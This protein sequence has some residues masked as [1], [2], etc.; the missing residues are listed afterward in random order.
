MRL[1]SVSS[2]ASE[3]KRALPA[4]ALAPARSRLLW[5]PV[6]LTVIVLGALAIARDWVPMPFPWLV[7]LGIG[8]SFGGLSFLAHEVLHGAVVRSMWQ[9]RLVGW[10]GFL[11]FF[12]SPRLWI[13]WHNRVHHGHANQPG[14]DPDAFPTLEEYRRR[15]T[16]RLVTDWLE[17]GR[18]RVAGVL[19]LL[20]GFSVHSLHMLASAKKSGLLSA[21]AR[22]WALLESAGAAAFWVLLALSIGWGPFMLVYA[23]PLLIANA[24]VMAHIFTNHGLSPLTPVNDPL[25]NS[26]SVTAPRWFEWITLRFGFHVEHHLFPWM[27][28]RHAPAVRSLVRAR[29]PE[30]YQSMPLWRAL[31]QLFV[32]GRVYKDGQTLMDVPAG[33]EWPALLPRAATLPE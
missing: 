7:S 20:I 13:A 33:T 24:M 22:R 28:S 25:I 17:P 31:H 19:S 23:L 30:R 32:T 6:H 1:R 9:R 21:K 29:W 11:P 4:R 12:V 27:S 15:R 26:L 8:M 14:V 2:Y 3:L 18:G 5:L 10:L 16:V